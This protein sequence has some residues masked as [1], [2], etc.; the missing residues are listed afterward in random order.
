MLEA[1]VG[2]TNCFYFVVFFSS[3]S[4]EVACLL[5]MIV[6]IVVTD[7]GVTQSV[8][9][10]EPSWNFDGYCDESLV[11]SCLPQQYANPGRSPPLNRHPL[12]FFLAHTNNLPFYPDVIRLVCSNGCLSCHWGFLALSEDTQ[13]NNFTTKRH[14]GA[15]FPSSVRTFDHG[16]V[17]RLVRHWLLAGSVAPNCSWRWPQ[18]EW[19]VF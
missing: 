9:L 8:V 19:S 12:N 2:S 13:M 3:Q 1:C 10:K 18:V 15:F 14:C 17:G 6:W 11:L 5:V 4:R 7:N 16:S